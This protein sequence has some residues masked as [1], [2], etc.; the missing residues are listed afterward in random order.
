MENIRDKADAILLSIEQATL[1]DEEA[2]LLPQEDNIR[3]IYE[4]LSKVL[5]SRNV[6]KIAFEKLNAKAKLDG[7]DLNASYDYKTNIF[8]GGVLWKYL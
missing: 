1:T 4:A 5:N 3:L 6:L 7:V 8:I 2:R